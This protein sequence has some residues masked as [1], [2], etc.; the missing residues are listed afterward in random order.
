MNVQFRTWIL[1]YHRI[2]IQRAACICAL[3]QVRQIW[4]C[5]EFCTTPE[6][7]YQSRPPK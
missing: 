3:L 4:R 6:N 5:A 7:P 1:Q 2:L